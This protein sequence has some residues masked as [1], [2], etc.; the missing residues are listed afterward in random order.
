MSAKLLAAQVAAAFGL[1]EPT[2][3]RDLSSGWT[4]NLRLDVPGTGALVARVHGSST[5]PER[6][7]AIHSARR[8]VAE[9]G[10]PAVPPLA[11]PDGSEIVKLPDGDLAELEP[12]VEWDSQMNS[13]PLL[14]KGFAILARTHDALRSA[15]I[16]PAGRTAPR[17]NHIDSEVAADA[18][19]RGAERMRG[20]NDFVMS[21][22]A[23]RVTNHVDAVDAAE[24]PLRDRQVRQ[25]VHGDFWD[26]NVL[27]RNG[28][29]A[30]LL[31]FDFMAERPRI[32]DLALTLYFFLL[33]PGKALP[34]AD[35]RKQVRRFL[36]A[37]DA[38]TVMKLSA[39][40]RAALPLAIARQPAWSVGR[41]ILELDDHGAREHA[42][43]AVG[44]LP[45][46][47]AILAE[48]PQWQ[49]ALA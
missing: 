30:V 29:P 8:A 27:F 48:L 6:L 41:W 46:A 47:Q 4:R 36:D 3:W 26:N 32:D 19:H 7:A 1:P 10:I 24:E 13:V 28:E 2:G 18:T 12:Y 25:V 22:F 23:D 42:A 14:Q 9:A 33:E 43:Y 11:T 39:D 35:D 31:D 37:Y 44:E 34:T 38:A 16:P 17:A 45:V 5:S 40:E 15:P 20:W 21:R 49:E